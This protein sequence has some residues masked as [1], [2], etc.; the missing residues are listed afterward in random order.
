MEGG[1]QGDLLSLEKQGLIN[2]QTS[3]GMQ[4]CAQLLQYSLTGTQHRRRTYQPA[5]KKKAKAIGLRA[6]A[7]L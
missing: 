6:S 5:H 3:R 4:T 2:E 7:S 1:F